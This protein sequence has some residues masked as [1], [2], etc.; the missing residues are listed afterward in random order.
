MALILYIFVFL[1]SCLTIAYSGTWAVNSLIKTG[2][3]LR[4]KKFIFIFFVLGLIFSLP[5]IFIG[6]SAAFSF[7]TELA[8]GAI[9]GSNIILF[10]LTIALIVFSEKTGKALKFKGKALRRAM[11]FSFFYAFLPLILLL[12]GALTRVD[13][14]IL[15]ASLGLYIKEFLS[16]Q[17]RLKEKLIP[18]LS[19]DSLKK[20][21]TKT[22]LQAAGIFLLSMGLLGAGAW[23]LVLSSAR[24]FSYFGLPLFVAGSLIV[25][26]GI[27][28]LEMIFGAK[29]IILKQKEFIP[30]IIFSPV[31]ISSTL[32]LGIALI[33]SPIRQIYYFS[34]YT[35][36]LVFTALAALAL[37]IFSK[38]GE[39]ITRKQARILLLIYALFFVIQLLV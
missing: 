38:T 19:K 25:A 7:K 23:A 6:M 18:E 33:I 30:G 35:N 15:I 10:T 11:L 24:I 8:L 31:I 13:G 27:S 34:P 22:A 14:V 39:E 21:E 17:K 16:Q 26:L 5:E 28:L 29:A 1:I 4:W 12:D 37:L 20:H 2:A 36:V 9:V 3:F 32:A